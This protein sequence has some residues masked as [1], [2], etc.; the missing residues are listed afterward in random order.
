MTQPNRNGRRC[1]RYRRQGSAICAAVAAIAVGGGGTA[2]A[3]FLTHGATPEV[4]RVTVK[5]VALEGAGGSVPLLTFGGGGRTFDIA[6]V[7]S[8]LPV[9]AIPI[10]HTVPA[11]DYTA[12][13]VTLG[14]TIQAAGS[15][16]GISGLRCR[17]R[18]GGATRTVGALSDVPVAD[19]HPTAPAET[20]NLS[21]PSGP[22]VATALAAAGFSRTADG[23]VWRHALTV[24]VAADGGGLPDIDL[25][26]DVAD[27]LQFQVVG[28][29]S[30]AVTPRVPRLSLGGTG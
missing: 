16:A 1:Y 27:A 28:M 11:G 7:G 19:A 23:L 6:S 18:P 3:D 17:T 4:Y 13:L 22:A 10:E 8:S 29:G 15:R 5:S 25:S 9:E 26:I 30:C 12:V 14:E 20:Q 21:L 24:S 2:T